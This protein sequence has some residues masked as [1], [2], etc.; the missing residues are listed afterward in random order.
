MRNPADARFT[1]LPTVRVY[2][3]DVTD[4]ATVTRALQQAHQDFGSLDVLVNNAG[5]GLAGPFESATVAQIQQQFAPSL[6]GV[7]SVARAVLPILRAQKAGVV[8]V[9]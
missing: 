7:F 2:A 5:Y 6:F 1:D 8:E 9:V 3:L 4:E